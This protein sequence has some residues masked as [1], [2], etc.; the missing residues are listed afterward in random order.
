MP[1]GISDITSSMVE[2]GSYVRL[3]SLTFSYAFPKLKVIKDLTLSVTATNLLTITNYSGFDPE[4]SSFNQSILQQ[5][6]DYAAYPAQR[7]YT[8]GLSCNF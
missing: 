7:S 3:K 8:F 5:G 6:I 2:D 1:F 4:V